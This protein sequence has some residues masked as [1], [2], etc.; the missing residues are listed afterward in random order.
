MD[1]SYNQHVTWWETND[2]DIRLGHVLKSR[3]HVGT[4]PFRATVVT[5]ILP[6]PAPTTTILVLPNLI[7][8][9][10]GA[11]DGAVV[12]FTQVLFA[13]ALW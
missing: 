8:L 9:A 13:N 7:V 12:A 1:I 4:T 5:L 2:K 6:Q 3:R 10:A 11:V